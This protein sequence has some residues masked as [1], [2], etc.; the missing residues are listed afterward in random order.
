MVLKA[1]RKGVIVLPKKL[2]E[3]LDI[4]EGDYVVAEVVGEELV[5]R[6]LKPRVVD[7]DPEVVA[8]ALREEHDLERTRFSR[9]ISGGETGS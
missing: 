8:R 1:H 5:L 9:M 6:A 4:G 2:R 7:V 3:V